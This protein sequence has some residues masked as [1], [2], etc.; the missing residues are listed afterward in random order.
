[1][2]RNDSP[3][4]TFD[5]REREEGMMAQEWTV[6]GLGAKRAGQCVVCGR[7]AGVKAWELA[8]CLALSREDR[9]VVDTE[10][11]EDVRIVRGLAHASCAGVATKGAIGG[12]RKPRGPLPDT[13]TA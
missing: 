3:A 11:L 1:M 5:G 10:G 9:V 13:I 2:K 7:R 4:A 12:G 8:D 6:D